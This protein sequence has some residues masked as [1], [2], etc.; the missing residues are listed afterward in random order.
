[1]GP[2]AFSISYQIGSHLQLLTLKSCVVSY[3]MT[4]TKIG[5]RL[6]C[7][8]RQKHSMHNTECCQLHLV[9]HI[10]NWQSFAAV[11]FKK[12][13]GLLHHDHHKN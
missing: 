8:D 5:V 4:T 9:F 2:I 7:V 10:P 6:G 12:L 11:D 13:C 3:I 1:M